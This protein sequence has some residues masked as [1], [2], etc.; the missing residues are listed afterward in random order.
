MQVRFQAI[1]KTLCHPEFISGS[2]G[3]IVLTAFIK[4]LAEML[5][6]VQHDITRILKSSSNST[7]GTLF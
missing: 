4:I 6:Q 7:N 1:K 3:K 2:V 5:K